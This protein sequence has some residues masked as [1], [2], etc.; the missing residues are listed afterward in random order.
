MFVLS[1]LITLAGLILL[2][3]SWII[4]FRSTLDI[5]LRKWSPR[6]VIRAFTHGKRKLDLWVKFF[7]T[8]GVIV[9]LL[10]AI[11]QTAPNAIAATYD[12]GLPTWCMHGDC[13]SYF[14]ARA[15]REQH[16]SS[17]GEAAVAITRELK[18]QPDLFKDLAIAG[19]LLVI[20]LKLLTFLTMV[21]KDI[22]EFKIAQLSH[23]KGD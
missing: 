13:Q 22:K 1:D 7:G 20:G 4:S 10:S 12:V 21:S 23:L 5:A 14:A 8:I 19:I 9:L 11:I 16:E 18:D 2:L 17:W 6:T 3:V 15:A